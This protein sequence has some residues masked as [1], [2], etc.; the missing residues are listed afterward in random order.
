[1]ALT[2]GGTPH[3][4]H[5]TDAGKRRGNRRN[6]DS[7]TDISHLV[8]PT[9]GGK[10]R[11]WITDRIME[12]QTIPH[13][14]EFLMHGRLPGDRKTDLP[15]L[16]VE[17]ARNMSRPFPEWAPAP[18]NVQQRATADWL[19]IRI[20]SH[21]D[22]SRLWLVA[23][24][25]HTMKSRLW[26]GI[27]PLSERRWNEL[28]LDDP[29]NFKNAC[30]YFMAV[31]DV[32]AYLNHPRTKT[33]LRTTYNLIWDHLK[34]FEQAVNKK[35]KAESDDYEQVS[36]TGL[37][38]QYI[39]AHYDF[40][41]TS[42]HHWVIEHIER[43]R[44]PIVL[45]IGS[46]QPGQ[47]EIDDRQMEL[48]DK[49]HDLAQN[50]TEADYIIFMPTDGYKGD[51]LPAKEREPLTA[52]QKAPFR[53]YPISWSAN[54]NLRG[55]DYIERVRFLNRK[56]MYD[57]YQR[58]GISF[59]TSPMADPQRLLITCISQIDAQT[60]ARHELRGPSEPLIDHWIEY[61]REPQP[62]VKGFAAF[63]L[64]H[65]HD[66][67]KWNEFKTRFEADIAD[68]GLGKKD[69]QDVRQACKIHWIDG[70]EE[71]V[72]AA[73]RKFNSIISDSAHLHH[74]MFFAIDE[75][76]LKSY[77]EPNSSKFVLAVDAQYESG[78]GAEK[79]EQDH[80]SPA[81]EGTLRVLGSLVWDELGAMQTTQNV[82]LHQLW[83][84]AMSDVEKVYRGHK[85]GNVLK[86][87]T[88]EET[89]AWEVLNAA[90]P[91][92][93]KLAARRGGSNRASSRPWAAR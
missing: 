13:F 44:E 41:S 16:T 38:Y 63:R 11:L 67:K 15:L 35:R 24:E 58:E 43:I 29:K 42:A 55:S 86:F 61:A 66:D 88:Y 25:L 73:R 28:Q 65:E 68:W 62:R 56:E 21:E 90:M 36:V 34:V 79:G 20:G 64:C 60:A 48:A 2:A 33:A 57:H 22:S 52:A 74:R 81:Y 31:I 4:R 83:P 82:F 59:A 9:S 30:Q 75:A 23:K 5:Y 45:E 71:S 12:P 76:T 69:I 77:L 89:C 50:T 32:F 72:E 53:E 6:T 51:S 1:M 37:W 26:E 40:M 8:P 49:I 3:H 54:I 7:P 78:E 70:K 91:F 84:F 47:S 85:P 18:F 19:G 46:Y 14:L 80:E 93:I 87:P 17:E 27:P 92:V 10:H 39:K